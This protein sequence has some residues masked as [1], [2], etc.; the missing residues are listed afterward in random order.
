[1]VG[2]GATFTLH[3][4]R[5]EAVP[6][7]HEAQAGEPIPS[8][9]GRIL[10]VEDN[11]EVGEFARQ[12]L[13]DLGYDTVLATNAAEALGVLEA[14]E[15]GF[16]LVFSDVVMPGMSGVELGQT[17]RKTWPRLPVVLTSGY[18]HVLAADTG[19]G[20]PLLHKPY[21]VEELSHV[22]QNARR[23]RPRPL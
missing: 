4:P 9:Q 5:T 3:L 14:G 22:L 10:V 19:H 2:A 15:D 16:D 23:G 1:V 11:A 20:F 6:D 17:I 18:S 8:I 21:S 7:A 12:L 13:E